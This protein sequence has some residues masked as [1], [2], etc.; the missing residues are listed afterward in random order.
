[1]V[2]IRSFALGTFAATIAV[3]VWLGLPRLLNALGLHRPYRIPPLDLRG[4]RA[5]IVTTSTSTMAETGKATG[6]FASE[7]TGSYY[8]FADA[9]MEVDVASIAGGPVPIEAIS[10]RWPL[11]TPTDR[12]YQQDPDF[13][14]KTGRSLPI[15][16]VEVDDYDIVFLAGGW[17]AAYDLGRSV[18][19][20]TKVSEAYAGGAVV[21]GVCHGPLGLLNVN[22]PDGSPLLKGRR[23][24]A[25]TDKQIAELRI[26]HTPMHPERD[27]R[28]AGVVFESERR[29]QDVLASHVVSDGRIVTGQNQNSAV[30]TAHRMMELAAAPRTGAPTTAGDR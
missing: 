30:E 17:G 21:G 10:L 11:A 15:G 29:F 14:A 19:L 7:M 23:V 13:R 20:G 16:E 18:E 5:L 12:R 4:K 1:M 6:V 24:T 9:G 27:L 3:L 22:A 2:L 26:T 8:A 25:V 28:A